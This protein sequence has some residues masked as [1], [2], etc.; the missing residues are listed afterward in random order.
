MSD[1]LERFLRYV[2]VDTQADE[3]SASYPS[4]AKQFDLG[5]MIEA[6]CRELGLT[7]VRMNQW[8]I[9]TAA[10]PANVDHDA[11]RIV[12]LA[13]VD[14]SPETSGTN[15]NPIVHED[16][17]GGDIALPGDPTKVIR[18]A[19][20]PDLAGLRGATIVTTDGTTLLGSDDKSGIAVIMTAAAELMASPGVPRGPITLCFTCDEEVGRGV[21]KIDVAGLGAACA[22][23]LDGPGAG[24]V[25]AETFS[26]DLAT[27]TARGVNTHPSEGKG[28]MVN[29]LRILSTF[30][31]RLPRET[32]SPEKT[33]GREGFLHPYAVEGGVAE[34]TARVL[35]RDFETGRLA[36]QAALLETIAAG[37]RGDFPGGALVIAI[38]P[39]YRNMRDGLAKEPRALPKALEAMVAAGLEPR[40]T[41]I[42]GG[43]DGS[44]LTELG[45]PCPNLAT[46]QHN[47]HSPLEWTSVEEMEIAVRVL[48]ELARAWSTESA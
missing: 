26:A 20:N 34:A 15:V 43:T 27:V 12:W 7:D 10:I 18:V 1:L 24:T 22:Y 23:T 6:E 9:V 21:D 32:L 46:G 25:D 13:H 37:V 14:T 11:P 35:L 33:A 39:Q 47:P 2:R 36:E 45:L 30:L 16:Y 29:A 42:R 40:T 17:A 41:I 8:G 44:R 5:R 48:V 31:A 19:E 3:A 4:T 38:R 28:R